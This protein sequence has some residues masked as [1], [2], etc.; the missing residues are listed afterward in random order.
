MSRVITF[1]VHITNST[2]KNIIRVCRYWRLYSIIEFYNE[3]SKNILYI[4]LFRI[5]YLETWRY[6]AKKTKRKKKQNRKTKKKK[7][8]FCCLSLIKQRIIIMVDYLEA[9]FRKP[10]SDHW[11]YRVIFRMVSLSRRSSVKVRVAYIILYEKKKI[12]YIE[13]VV[14][15]RCKERSYLYFVCRTSGGTCAIKL[16]PSLLDYIHA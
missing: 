6:V 16:Q 13:R 5:I 4:F 12:Y 14:R 1:V 9:W 3:K 15:L 2:K 11:T 8:K 7:K 10:A